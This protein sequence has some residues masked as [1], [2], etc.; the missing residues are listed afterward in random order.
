MNKYRAGPVY[1]SKLTL[2][3]PMKALR[4]LGLAMLGLFIT[5]APHS[6]SAQSVNVGVFYNQLAPYGSWLQAS[7]YGYVWQPNVGSGWRPYSDGQWVYTDDGWYWNSNEDWGW[8]TYHYGRW[9][10]LDGYGWCWVP[11]STWAPAW[12]SW[13]TSN[14]YVGWAPLPPEAE[15]QPSTGIQFG[16][17]FGFDIGP[18]YYNF[19]PNRYFGYG[20]VGR[21]CL[22]PQNNVNIIEQ[23]T[24]VTNIVNNNNV[25]YNGGPNYAALSRNAQ[26]RRAQLDRVNAA[27][28]AAMR[29]RLQGNRLRV[30]TPHVNRDRGLRPAHVAGRVPPGRVNRGWANIKDQQRAAAVRQRMKQEAQNA[31]HMTPQQRQAAAQRHQRQ[32]AAAQAGNPAAQQTAA[33]RRHERQVAAAQ[34][35][36]PAAQQA[37]AQRRHERQVA[38]AQAGNPAAQQTTAQRRRERQAAA[39]AASNPN[40]TAREQAA[41]AANRNRQTH[42]AAVPNPASQTMQERR[43]ARRQEAAR[44]QNSIQEARLSQERQQAAQAQQRRHNAAQQHQAQQPHPQNRPPQQHHAQQ[45]RPQNRPPQQQP[46]PQNRPPQQHQQHAQGGGNGGNKN[47]KKKH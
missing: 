3:F 25:V 11:G 27:D 29:G 35:G 21:Y 46:R 14:D 13:R 24:N 6:A 44:Q 34:A 17:S 8:A 43:Q 1:I 42:V 38:A 18:G 20:D 37:T 7:G 40:A 33:Q 28:P 2:G 23:T 4:T 15:W 5:W 16:V 19:C 12:V 45:P 39:A 22:P 9:V 41:R 32:V 47:E 10:N 31:R 30:A 36:N 26:I